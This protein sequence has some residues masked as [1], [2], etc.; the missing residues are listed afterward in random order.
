M[1]ILTNAWVLFSAAAVHDIQWCI[2]NTVNP[3]ITPR[4]LF[5]NKEILGGGLFERGAYLN[6]G[7]INLEE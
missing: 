7:L 5:T 1:V 4:G 6:G 3:R 2:T